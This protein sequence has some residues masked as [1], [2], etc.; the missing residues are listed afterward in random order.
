MSI[1]YAS[2]WATQGLGTFV[3]DIT[4]PSGESTSLENDLG[5][6]SVTGPPPGSGPNAN[7][8]IRTTAAGFPEGAAISTASSIYF[9]FGLEGISGAVNRAAVMVR[10]IAYL[11]R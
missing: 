2:D 8:W 10:A 1:A 7:N 4:L 6:W 5:G 11:L 3:D 9:G